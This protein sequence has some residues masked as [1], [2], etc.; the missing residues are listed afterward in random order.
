MVRRP[1]TEKYR[2]TVKFDLKILLGGV[3]CKR[4]G[5][6][7]DTEPFMDNDRMSS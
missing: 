1:C 4:K 6:R 2:M 5:E 7:A 3:R